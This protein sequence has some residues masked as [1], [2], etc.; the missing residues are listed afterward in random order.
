MAKVE[1]VSAQKAAVLAGQDAALE[2]GLGACYDQGLID[3]GAP[4]PVG[5]SQEEMDA[6][7]AVAKAAD[8]EALNAAVA[9]VQGHLDA[10]VE[11]DNAD[12]AALAALQAKL[13][14]IKALLG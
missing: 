7:V 9:E 11:K 12:V 14:Q 8:A 13:D 6:A 10:M 5:F 4:A 1:V 2:L 3:A